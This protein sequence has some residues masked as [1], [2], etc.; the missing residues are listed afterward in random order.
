[1]GRN[2][3]SF[4]SKRSG[5]P[6]RRSRSPRR[7]SRERKRSRERSRRRRSERRRGDRRRSP[8]EKSA[9]DGRAAASG[10]EKPSPTKED[11]SDDEEED[12]PPLPN[13]LCEVRSFSEMV[14]MAPKIQ[15]RAASMKTTELTEACAAAARVKF[16]DGDLLECVLKN[17][18]KR[19][20]SRSDALGVTGIVTVMSSL[21]DLNAYNKDF[22]AAAAKIIDSSFDRLDAS[23]TSKA[24]AAFKA[25]K[26]EGDQDL[27]EALTRKTKSERYEVAKRELFD[28]Q[29]GRMY[30]GTLDLQGA[31]MD[32]ERALLRAPTTKT[33]RLSRR[34]ADTWTPGARV[35]ERPAAAQQRPA[36]AA[37]SSLPRGT[38]LPR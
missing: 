6:K 25:A 3:L 20:K 12:G 4:R 30:G 38:L 28:R 37:V 2:A 14:R 35:P 33:T 34:G 16:Y 7:R 29:M 1:M 36:A 21:A 26:H 19:L 18:Q 27:I 9:D 13:S 32:A 24:L 15:R 17:L 8:S 31:P 5:S 22:F 23:Q 11:P 10:E